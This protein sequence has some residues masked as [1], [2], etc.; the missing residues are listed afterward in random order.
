[1]RVSDRER[2]AVVERLNQA[3]GEGRLTL[4]EFGERAG[5]AYEAR[6]QGEL[7]RL[8]VD[9]PPARAV[10][11]VGR[12]STQLVPV[13]SIKRGGRWRLERDMSIGTVVGSIKLNL[14]EAEVVGTE[15]N[16]HVKAVVGSVKV[17]IP[18]GVR[19]EVDGTSVVGSRTVAEDDS[20]TH[21]YAP[22]LRLHID[23]VVGSVKIYRT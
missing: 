21:P 3:T 23:T 16:L 22:I 20:G 11:P 1:M 8:V 6:T 9:L 13:G 17:W 14:R 7:Q 2:E 4:E 5:A 18:R 10:V 15:V 12:P 19:V